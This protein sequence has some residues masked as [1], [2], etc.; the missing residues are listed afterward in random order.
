MQSGA[1][2]FLDWMRRR[3]FNQTETATFFGW[4]MTFISQ[5][6]R[7]KRKPGLTNAIR[8]ERE[9]GIPVESWV[10]SQLDKDAETILANDRNVQ[11]DKA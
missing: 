9:T 4:D 2:Q 11:S 7:G 8:I 5:L 1:A 10:S 3:G 6:V